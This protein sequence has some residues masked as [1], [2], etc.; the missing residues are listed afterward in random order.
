MHWTFLL[1]A[2]VVIAGSSLLRIQDGRE[3]IVPI[4]DK[5]LPGTCTFLRF[6]GIP[7]PGCGLTRSFISI[8]HGDFVGAWRFNPAGLFFFAVVAFQIPYRILQIVRIRRGDQEHRFVAFDSW[9]LV[10]LVVVLLLQWVSAI[11][12]HNLA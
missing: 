9:V 6:T 1:I 12:L 5:P 10:G 2:V 8:G 7:C 3:V 4:L 11:L